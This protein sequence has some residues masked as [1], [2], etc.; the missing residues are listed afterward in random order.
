MSNISDNK[1]SFYSIVISFLFLI[2]ISS[3][4]LGNSFLFSNAVSINKFSIII[5]PVISLIISKYILFKDKKYISWKF[6]LITLIIFYL[7]IS[8]LLFVN[9]FVWD[10]GYDS[11]AYHQEGII[12]LKDNWNPYLYST[13]DINIWVKHY[14]KAPWIFMASLYKLTGKI[15]CTKVLSSLLPIILSLLSF[16]F[17]YLISNKKLLISLLGSVVLLLN[18]INISQIFTFYVDSILGIYILTLI[19]IIICILFFKDLIYFKYFT[20]FNV[21]VFLVNIKF[22]G[23]A[24]SIIILGAFFIYSLI[25]NNKKYN[26]KLIIYFLSTFLLS[27]CFVGF[28]PYITNLI[29]N[30]NPLYPLIGKGKIDIMTT[31]TPE[32]FRHENEL[33]KLKDSLL[34]EPTFENEL[35][36]G[37]PAKSIKDLLKIKKGTIELYSTPDA[38][39]RGFGIYSIFIIPISL[40]LLIFNFVFLKNKQFKIFSFILLIFLF[41]G[42]FVLGNFWWAR[43]IP[44]IWGIPVFLSLIIF[45]RK[46]KIEKIIACGLLILMLINSLITLP[47]IIKTKINWSEDIKNQI[48]NQSVINIPEKAFMFSYLNKAKEFNKNYELPK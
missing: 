27:V 2:F 16:G 40:I 25:F 24:Y 37:Y 9:N 28:N 19:I 7:I 4:V 1:I 20:L 38:R 22:T 39:L 14:P 44:F 36:G 18:P 42:I 10:T 11:L 8:L 47:G 6:L 26:K 17:F 46:Y 45:K 23:L 35:N 15:E 12:R 29:N 5:F 31:N 21:V 34:A 33:K 3:V 41:G 13:P 30:G 32:Y 43:Y 48:L